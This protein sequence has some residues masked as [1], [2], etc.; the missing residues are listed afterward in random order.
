VGGEARKRVRVPDDPVLEILYVF[1]NRLV[2]LGTPRQ[3]LFLVLT[4]DSIYSLSAQIAQIGHVIL[5]RL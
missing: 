4:E 2:N 1:G 5:W 3:K